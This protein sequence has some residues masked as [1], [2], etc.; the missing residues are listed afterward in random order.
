MAIYRP[1][2]LTLASLTQSGKANIWD[3]STTTYGTLIV[4]VGDTGTGTI[5]GFSAV[6]VTGTLHCYLSLSAGA[7]GVVSLDYSLD[8]GSTWTNLNSTGS[9]LTDFTAAI[10]SSVIASNIRV[11]FI[12]DATS[13]D[14][15]SGPSAAI[16][17]V[18]ID[19]GSQGKKSAAMCG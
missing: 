19:T 10:T 16:Y 9:S 18:W 13:V 7:D 3:G 2:T 6:S 12:L 17:E 11:R 15:G 14:M 5:A 1:S 8:A 4:S